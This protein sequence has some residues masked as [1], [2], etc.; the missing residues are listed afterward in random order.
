MS[1]PCLASVNSWI[2]VQRSHPISSFQLD[3]KT[4]TLVLFTANIAMLNCA[5]FCRDF[6]KVLNDPGAACTENGQDLDAL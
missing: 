6:Q 1:I 4:N 2:E 3:S 5:C